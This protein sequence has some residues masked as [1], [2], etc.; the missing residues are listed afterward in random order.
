MIKRLSKAQGVQALREL[1]GI[2]DIP[3]GVKLAA[4]YVSIDERDGPIVT[5]AIDE[6]IMQ[7]E[8]EPIRPAI[9]ERDECTDYA[10]L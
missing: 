9:I 3:H 5:V 8:A 6:P 4:I 1:S 7:A 10:G 2:I